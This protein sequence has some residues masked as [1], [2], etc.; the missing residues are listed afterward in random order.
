M[1]GL[2]RARIRIRCAISRLYFDVIGKPAF[3]AG[4]SFSLA[5]AGTGSAL[6]CAFSRLPI[7]MLKYFS[8]R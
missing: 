3:T 7:V 8:F 6:K 5:S 2:V 1:E 4:G